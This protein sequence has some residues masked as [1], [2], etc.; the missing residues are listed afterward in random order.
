MFRFI[1]VVWCL[2]ISSISL[3]AQSIEADSRKSFNRFSVVKIDNREALRKA[4]SGVPFENESSLNLDSAVSPTPSFDFD[5][6]GKA[7]ISVF[8]PSNNFWYISKSS[9]GVSFIKWGLERDRLVPGDYDG[10]GRTDIAVYRISPS[11]V[12]PPTFLFDNVWYILRSSDNTSFARLF[13]VI[14]DLSGRIPVP[15]DYDGDGRTDLATYITEDIDRSPG[16]FTVLQSSTDTKVVTQ[17]GLGGDAVVP[18][19]YDG[20]GR[21]DY[22]VVRVDGVWFILQSSTGTIRIEYFGLRRDRIVPGDYDG[23][24]KAD[25]AVWRPSNGFWYWINSS[26]RSFNSFKFGLPD[27]QP[28][29]AD[30]DGDGRTDVAVFRPSTGFWYLQRSRDGFAAQQFGL[31]GDIPIPNVYVRFLFD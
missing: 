4:K 15:A 27:D 30:Y 29:P 12:V 3:F 6:D 31:S 14:N 1:F 23:D 28:V 24:G 9:G 10:D 21:A 25:I 5:G 26:N 8:R 11:P 20:D 18:A 17:W 13:E 16:N 7:D 22:A 19:D 2:I